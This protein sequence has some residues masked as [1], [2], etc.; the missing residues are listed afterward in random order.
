MSA[1]ERFQPGSKAHRAALALLD[2]WGWA[3][4]QASGKPLGRLAWDGAQWGLYDEPDGEVSELCAQSACPIQCVIEAEMTHQ[5]SNWMVRGA[6][7]W[8]LGDAL[9]HQQEH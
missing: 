8:P 1:S 9:D 3:E 2:A 6:G 5:E 4:P 7:R